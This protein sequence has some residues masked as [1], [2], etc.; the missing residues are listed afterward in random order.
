M[1]SP[2]PQSSSKT[3]PSPP[4]VPLCPLTLPQSCSPSALPPSQPQA[5]TDL[6]KGIIFSPLHRILFS[7]ETYLWRLYYKMKYR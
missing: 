4:K 1:V 6:P 7:Y 2:S 5:S 3:L